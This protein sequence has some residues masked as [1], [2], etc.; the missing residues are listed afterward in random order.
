MK[1]L[2]LSLLLCV[3]Y[4]KKH[5]GQT[6]TLGASS[7]FAVFTAIGAFN[8]VG[9]TTNVVG[10]VGTNVGAFNAFPPGV[11]VGQIHVA[12][13]VS[14]QAAIDVDVAYSFTAA[15]TCGQVL[16]STLGNGQVLTPNIYCIG[17][18]ST[19][20]DTLFLDGEGDPNA[21]FIF[22]IDGAL[23]TSTF[24]TIIL[25]NSA[26]IC[27][28]FWQINGAVDI[29]ENATFRGNILVN[30]A[31]SLL[32]AA[33]FYGRA[34]SRDGAISMANNIVRINQLPTPAFI[35]ADGPTTFCS[36]DSVIISGNNGGVWN[37][38]SV[39][40]SITVTESGTYF[41]TTSNNCGSSTSN[42][43]TTNVY[44]STPC[45]ITGDNTICEGSST[46]LCATP[47]SA[48][49]VWSNGSTTSCIS[50]NVAGNYSV[51]V[52]DVNG[53]TSACNI[54]VTVSALPQC[55]ITGDNTICEGSST[56]LCATPGAI[57][58]V[59]SN[60]STASCISVNVAGNYSVT[61]TDV[62]GCTSAC[63]TNV[64]V[65]ALPICSITG[66]NTI[67]EGSST[68][69][70]ATPGAAAYVWSNGSTASCISVNVAGNY[71]VTI[72]D[73]NGCTSSCNKALLLNSL[74]PCFIEGADSFCEGSTHA[75]C[76]IGGN[77]YYDWSSGGTFDCIFVT[78]GGSYSVT[79]TDYF[80]CSSICAKTLTTNPVPLCVITGNDIVC[81]GGTNE[82]CLPPGLA[83]YWWEDGQ[84]TNCIDG[85]TAGIYA[86]TITDA[87]GCKSTCN[88][89]VSIS[90]AEECIISGDSIICENDVV[91]LCT[92]EDQESYLWS[93]GETTQCIVVSA[94]GDYSVTISE[95]PACFSNCNFTV[96]A[97]PTIDNPVIYATESTVFCQGDSIT[98]FGNTNNGIWNTGETSANI[99]VVSPGIYFVIN[100][101]PCDSTHSNEIAVSFMPNPTASSIS[102]LSP[103][104]FC[105]G[106]SVLLFGNL[107]GVWSTGATSSSITVTTSG[108]YYVINTNACGTS[109]SNEI[110][111]D[112]IP[113]PIAS[114]I[115]T[116]STTAFC[117]GES[118]VLSGN[119]N[120]TWNT[121]ETSESIIVISSGNYF[122]TNR[123]PCGFSISNKIDVTVY[124]MPQCQID[125]SLNMVAGETA[126]LCGPEG[127]QSYKWSTFD[128]TRCISVISSSEISVTV[129]NNDICIDSC[130]VNVVF[131]EI[132]TSDDQVAD[133][134]QIKLHVYPNPFVDDVRI[135]FN[136]KLPVQIIKIDVLKVTGEMVNE[137]FY[138]YAK[139]DKWYQLTLD[140]ANLPAGIYMVRFTSEE[141]IIYKRLIK[142][143]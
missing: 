117:K 72:T 137:I 138:D 123:N 135:D 82:L 37:N 108:S 43:I 78:E 84:N 61:T 80:G 36:N 130:M 111:V 29:G 16:T 85:S 12:D 105:E 34:L 53:C 119:M 57:A 47:G 38:G 70:C 8:N 52:T 44:A 35:I 97:A 99:I 118:I 17:E 142:L 74:P 100:S 41:V 7:N 141:N 1:K 46:E 68:Q 60:G 75:L 55:S 87:N 24:S 48:T 11:L 114:N 143:N 90:S 134:N 95:N 120:G 88:K 140:G 113:L 81:E 21:I 110:I 9:A 25:S 2:F 128:K 125:G 54:N 56:Q 65:S 5:F 40:P 112:V 15:L 102:H 22:Q 101:G 73:V 126:I 129:T 3:L 136:H 121:G 26:S 51:T 86:I 71:S 58:Y 13:P 10:D 18:A 20:N 109:V 127:V 23:S 132:S 64:T 83:D 103:T 76:T 19:M 49:Y 77:Y 91:V 133:A 28:I 122:V 116:A 89:V 63:N 30:G 67:C 31:I 94:A 92:I 33:S 32:E 115:E 106:D 4:S 93:T 139:S 98:L 6:P 79:V 104:T 39:S 14:V 69:L 45:S 50:V 107:N 27:N 62:T 96:T 59:W 124:D 42:S 66:D 131:S